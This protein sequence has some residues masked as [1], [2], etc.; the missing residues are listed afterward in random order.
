MPVGLGT[1]SEILSILHR[2]PNERNQMSTKTEIK[3]QLR[4]MGMAKVS[5]DLMRALEQQIEDTIKGK[6]E[7]IL[8]R[9]NDAIAKAKERSRVELDNLTTETINKVL[10]PTN[11]AKLMEEQRKQAQGQKE[12]V[13]A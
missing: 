12:E 2:I 3:N 7:S 6:K 4:I 1:Q 11:L 8:T 9:Q 5:T 10:A 13:G